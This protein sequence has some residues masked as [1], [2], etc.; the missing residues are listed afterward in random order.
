MSFRQRVASN[1][2]ET[3][4]IRA[5]FIATKVVMDDKTKTEGGSSLKGKECTQKEK[6]KAKKK[7]KIKAKKK[8]R[9]RSRS[10]SP[11]NCTLQLEKEE[12][13]TSAEMNSNDGFKLHEIGAAVMVAPLLKGAHEAPRYE[14]HLA[15][16]GE[17][18]PTVIR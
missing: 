16:E 5:T 15:L 8:L 14:D 1:D 18:H 12:P 4:G 2:E 9:Q 11:S 13:K 7:T 17:E 6:K 3:G 10:L